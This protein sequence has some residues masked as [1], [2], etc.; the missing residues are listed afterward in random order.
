MSLSRTESFE[1]K[2][3]IP[4]PSTPPRPKLISSGPAAAA[5]AE[6]ASKRT[7]LQLQLTNNIWSL[8]NGDFL[9]K[10]IEADFKSGLLNT[11]LSKAFKYS[12]INPSNAYLNKYGVVIDEITFQP[13]NIEKKTAHTA[14]QNEAR[15]AEVASRLSPD[16]LSRLFKP[17]DPEMAAA[18]AAAK[19]AGSSLAKLDNKSGG[20]YFKCRIVDIT[21]RNPQPSSSIIQLLLRKPNIPEF[22]TLKRSDSLSSNLPSVTPVEDLHI[23]F[24]GYNRGLSNQCHI[25]FRINNAVFNRTLIFNLSN[26]E[27]KIYDCKTLSDKIGHFIIANSLGYLPATE[28]PSIHADAISNAFHYFF[29]SLE[30]Y[31]TTKRLQDPNFRQFDGSDETKPI[32]HVLAEF[33]TNVS[34]KKYLKYKMKYLQLKNNKN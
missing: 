7:Q 27:I 3:P 34:Y 10:Q 18:A 17:I 29:T 8:I 24:H 13:D 20:L 2:K 28:T 31:L 6:P 23:S 9:R 33:K 15:S 5:A 21:T 11:E 32:G 1:N 14:L 30:N 25:K 16:L 19:A 12:L 26:N 22:G 4:M